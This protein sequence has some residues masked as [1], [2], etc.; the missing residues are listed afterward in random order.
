MEKQEEISF[1]FMVQVRDKGET[2][3]GIE[4]ATKRWDEQDF[5]FISIAKVT[6]YAPQSDLDSVESEADC[7]N[8]IFTPWHSLVSHQPLGGINRLRQDVYNRSSTHRGADDP[9]AICRFARRH[10]HSEFKGG[11]SITDLPHSDSWANFYSIDCNQPISESGL[12]DE[13]K[14]YAKNQNPVQLV[15][16]RRSGNSFSVIGKSLIETPVLGENTFKL[17]Q[18]IK[19]AKGDLVGWYY[20]TTGSIAFVK[21][22]GPWLLN[23]LTASVVFGN[24]GSCDNAIQFSSLRTYSIQVNGKQSPKPGGNRVIKGGGSVTD[25]PLTDSWVNFYSIDASHPICGE[26]SLTEW[27]IVAKNQ[28][29]VQLVIYRRTGN[30]FTVIGKSRMEIPV[31]GKNRFILD[32][33]ISVSMGDLV[34]WYN[35]GNCCIAFTRFRSFLL[36]TFVNI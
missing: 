15:I 24:Q 36:L 25:R 26:G 14:I 11:N 33:P 16:Y 13:W 18:P 34:G 30:N 10:D 29:P 35:P 31:V 8:L 5:P 12:L 19:V 3:L 9:G 7:E 20:P 1:D 22:D 2:D 17:V 28:N 23:D 4:D 27:N 32:Q 6:I 21:H